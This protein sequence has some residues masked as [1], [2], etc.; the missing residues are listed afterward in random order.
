MPKLEVATDEIFACEKCGTTAPPICRHHKG[1]DAYLA[2]WNQGI[3]GNYRRYLD[4]C[5]LCHDCHRDIHWIYYVKITKFW[6]DRTPRG[7]R[8]IRA[9]CIRLCDRWLAGK[10]I[11][12]PKMTKEFRLNFDRWLTERDMNGA[13]SR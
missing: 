11:K 9:R 13:A 8:N 2:R 3:R 1:N 7:A 4:C 12:V 6:V 10:T 5:R